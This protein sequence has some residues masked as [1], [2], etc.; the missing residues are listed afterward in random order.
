M[1]P[2]VFIISI[3]FGALG[4]ILMKL[5]AAHLGPIELNS[6]QNVM[7][8]IWK[9]LTNFT[10]LGGMGLYFLS[11]VAWTYL[12]TRLDVSYVQPIL[13]LT[14]LVTPI[15]AFFI[16]GEQIPLARWIG[17]GVIII[18]VYIIARTSVV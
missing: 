2:V 18:G 7:K 4:A 5:G 3:V 10:I 9:L 13:S 12:L 8:F 16:V 17:I 14:Y 6:F 1:I 15:L 11:A